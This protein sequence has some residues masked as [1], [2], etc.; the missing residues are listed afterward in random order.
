MHRSLF[1]FTLTVICVLFGQLLVFEFR[2]GISV[3]SLLVN[4][5]LLLAVLHLLM[6]FVA[7]LTSVGPTL[8]L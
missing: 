7:T 1:K 3:S 8:F 6:L 2:L 5:V 4:I